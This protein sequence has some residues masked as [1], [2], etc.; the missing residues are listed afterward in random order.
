MSL[1]E[2]LL[3]SAERRAVVSVLRSHPEWTLEHL[4]SLLEPDGARSP[5]LRKLTLGELL[6][7]PSA[8]YALAD[9]GGPPIDP[10]QLEAA[11]R[12]S[13]AEFDECVRRVIAAAG[14]RVGAAYLRARVGGPRWKLQDSLK[15]LV[16]AGLIERS[17]ATSS[18]RYWIGAK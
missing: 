8:A 16:A 15:R 9:D 4:A 7:D 11:K 6:G 12:Q 14:D 5:L 3:R 13:G 18:T 1:L 2:P 10:A 17:G